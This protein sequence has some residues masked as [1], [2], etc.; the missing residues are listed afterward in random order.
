MSSPCVV[1]ATVDTVI[2]GTVGRT[3]E[4]RR[5]LAALKVYSCTKYEGI[6]SRQDHS[7]ETTR[8]ES[9]TRTMMDF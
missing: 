2:V 1:H 5:N 8:K 3:F 7:L 4:D 9:L 6:P